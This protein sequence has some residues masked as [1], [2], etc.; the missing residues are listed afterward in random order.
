MDREGRRCRP[1]T[2]DPPCVRTDCV[3]SVVTN[4]TFGWSYL[5]NTTAAST[6]WLRHTYATTLWDRDADP[7]H[8]KENL[9]HASFDTTMTYA[10]GEDAKRHEEAR[11][12]GQTVAD[13][14]D[15]GA[16]RRD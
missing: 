9:G 7:R 8:I 2:T 14:A 15:T 6:H 3:K 16:A 12:L 4:T 10:H 11:T 1:D 13:A 5:C